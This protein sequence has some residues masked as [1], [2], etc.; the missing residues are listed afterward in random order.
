LR[1]HRRTA[2]RK[3]A[4][5]KACFGSKAADV[6]PSDRRLRLLPVPVTP[7]SRLQMLN[8][9]RSILPLLVVL[10]AN[11]AEGQLPIALTIEGRVG[12]VVPTGQFEGGSEGLEFGPGPEVG[13]AARFQVA[14][15][16]DV[17][18]GVSRAWFE[19]PP[20]GRLG[21]ERMAVRQSVEAGLHLESPLPIGPARPWVRGLV[22]G[23]TLA[24]SGFGGRQ[25]SEAGLGFGGGVGAGIPVGD[26]FT[27][28]P[29]VGYQRT[30]VL[31]RFDSFPDRRVLMSALSFK[32]GFA[33]RL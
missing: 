5:A 24:F 8:T 11:P 13:A 25:T 21:L 4:R 16:S 30:S 19:C 17:L 23:Q 12:G 29:G 28:Q 33:L 3:A 22:L 31:F 10:T 27:L 7:D 9:A 14:S 6:C 26:R 2:S 32:L 18:I 20:C 1:A 15:G